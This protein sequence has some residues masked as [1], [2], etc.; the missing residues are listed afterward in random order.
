MHG[1]AAYWNGTLSPSAVACWRSGQAPVLVSIAA[2][3][4]LVDYTIRVG[5]T[6][7]AAGSLQLPASL[8]LPPGATLSL[9]VPAGSAEAL[10][11]PDPRGSAWAS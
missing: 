9:S 8:V 5:G 6:D 1:E 11:I 2:T 3:V 10:V 4:P 7:K